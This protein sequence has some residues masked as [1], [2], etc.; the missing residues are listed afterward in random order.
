MMFVGWFA[1]ETR[2]LWCCCLLVLKVW[3]SE[4]WLKAH[5]T[6]AAGRI[7]NVEEEEGAGA[8]AAAAAGDGEA[9]GVEAEADEMQE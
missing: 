1:D 6:Q 4:D 2:L 7:A 8:A 3:E 5:G 9:D